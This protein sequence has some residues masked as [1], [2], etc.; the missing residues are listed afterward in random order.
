MSEK[1]QEATGTLA[2]DAD[3]TDLRKLVAASN[4]FAAAL[5]DQ[6]TRSGG[7][8][9]FAPTSISITLA[10]TYAG[11]RSETSAEM[12]RTLG[13]PMLDQQRLHAAFRALAA[14]LRGAPGIEMNVANA[15]FGQRDAG[16]LPDFLAVLIERYGAGLH[17]VN[18]RGEAE[19][20]PWAIG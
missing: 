13:F 12:A 4:A 7:N 5:H 17:E 6:V 9:F 10:M 16:F 2:S 20:A 1:R 19:Q 15:L 14:A 18:F 3:A 8:I 11:A